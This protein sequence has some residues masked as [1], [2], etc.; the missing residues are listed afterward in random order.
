MG[1][2]KMRQ[3]DPPLKEMEMPKGFIVEKKFMVVNEYFT[4]PKYPLPILLKKLA[5]ESEYIH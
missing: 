2:V 3:V 5:G 4:H 1:D